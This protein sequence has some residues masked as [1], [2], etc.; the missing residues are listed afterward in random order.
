MAIG[1]EEPVL[2]VLIDILDW[3]DLYNHT[4][5]DDEAVIDGLAFRGRWTAIASPAKAGKSTVI[6]ALAVQAAQA[7]HTVI[8]VDA[9]MGRGDV[10]E[11]VEDWMNLKPDDLA[12]LHYTDLPPK[13]DVVQ[14]AM[15]LYHTC[16]KYDPALVIIDGLNGVVNG[17]EN[18]D[19]TW[20]DMFELAIAPL[21]QRGCAIITA[22]NTGHGDKTRPRGSSVKLDKA[23]AIVAME[24]TDTG[25]KFTCN[26]RRTSSYPK[27]QEYTVTDASEEGPA[28]SVSRNGTHAAPEGTNRINALLDRLG[29]P[30]DIG[31]R[32]ARALL[33]A[34]EG[35]A[36]KNDILGAM[37]KW[38][39]QQADPL[40]INSCRPTGKDVVSA[41][42]CPPDHRLAAPGTEPFPTGAGG[43]VGADERPLAGLGPKGGDDSVELGGGPTDTASGGMVEPFDIHAPTL[44]GD[45]PESQQGSIGDHHHLAVPVVGDHLE[46]TPGRSVVPDGVPT[47]S[48]PPSGPGTA[49][50]E[51]EL[52]DDPF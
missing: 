50:H 43:P 20:R 47:Y 34:H 45:Q 29:A 14:G 4:D 36:P 33:I 11:R 52:E 28:M 24:R 27:E 44:H 37:L 46:E 23:D 12:N 5:T 38:R 35:Q 32:P 8:Y 39:K 31:R 40:G 3:H 6:L 19:T 42:V 26:H 48:T 49:G 7:G 2:A 17:A 18:D 25:V 9:E 1:D 13:L 16:E 51:N 10:L 30:W 21:K 22:D 15:A 41:A